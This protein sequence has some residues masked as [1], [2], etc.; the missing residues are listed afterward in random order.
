MFTT[1]VAEKSS[2]ELGTAWQRYSNAERQ[3]WVLPWE[4]SLQT[5]QGGEGEALCADLHDHPHGSEK[6][7]LRLAAPRCDHSKELGCPA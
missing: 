6:G 3:G 5:E 7:A 4:L 1:N 2:G